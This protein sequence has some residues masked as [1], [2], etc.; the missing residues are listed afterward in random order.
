LPGNFSREKQQARQ[1]EGVSDRTG[2]VSIN[3]WFWQIKIMA[4]GQR[5]MAK[6]RKRIVAIP[7]CL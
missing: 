2:L 7:L 6:G 4:K 1:S 5:R 3:R